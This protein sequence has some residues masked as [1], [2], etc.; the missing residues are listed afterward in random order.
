MDELNVKTSSLICSELAPE[1]IRVVTILPGKPPSAMQC[2]LFTYHIST[3]SAAHGQHFFE[4]DLCS[5]EALSYEWGS[6]QNPIEITLNDQ[7]FWVTTNLAEALVVLR[8]PTSPRNLWIDAL[9]INQSN[10]PERNIQVRRMFSI[11]QT[12]RRSS[13]GL[14]QVNM[15]ATHLYRTFEISL[16]RIRCSVPT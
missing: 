1:S 13:F 2:W 9:C 12:A 3:K 6:K 4:N 14:G 11:Y 15:M 7:P 16:L 10:I 8:S 5:Y